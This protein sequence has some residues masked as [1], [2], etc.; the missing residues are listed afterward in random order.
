MELSR[1]PFL[2]ISVCHV[3]AE[4][5]KI[6]EQVITTKW[7]DESQRQLR[8]RKWDDAHDPTGMNC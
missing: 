7:S 4:S 1:E 8:N 2:C 6:S 5:A 3:E